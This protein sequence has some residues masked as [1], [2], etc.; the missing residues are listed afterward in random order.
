MNGNPDFTWLHTAAGSVCAAA[1]LPEAQLARLL[2]QAETLIWQHLDRPVKISHETLLV[3]AEV[4]WVEGPMR[5]AYKQ[6][7]PRGWWK[8]LCGRF[9]VSRARRGWELAQAL[10]A[11]NIPTPRPLLACEPRGPWRRRSSYLATQWIADAENLHLYGWRLAG[12]P[13]PQRLRWASRCAVNLGRLLGRMH[14]AGVS[15]RDLKGANLLA[16]QQRDDVAVFLVDVDGV[17]ISRR[18]SAR[19]RAADLARLAAGLEAHPWV[20]RS[21]A[22]RLLRAYAGEFPAGTVAWKPLWRD[23]AQRAGHYAEHK[24][25]R[26]QQ[27]L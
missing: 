11:R 15:H 8:S 26:G 27:V 10:L 12:Y 19:R 18:L 7:R 9:R 4:P 6:F 3:E 14:A 21:I 20:S 23:I 24:H 22:C 2:E 16:V 13:L 5:V 1:A 25:R 17:R